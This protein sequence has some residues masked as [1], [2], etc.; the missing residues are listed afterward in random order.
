MRRSDNQHAQFI[1]ETT[2]LIV[3]LRARGLEQTKRAHNW[4]RHHIAKWKM[5][6]GALGLR[7]PIM[8]GG[9]F[10]RAHGV[11]LGAGGNILVVFSHWWDLEQ[12]QQMVER[13]GPMRQKQAGHE[14]PVFIHHIV[15]AGTVDELVMKRRE[16]KREVQDLLLEALKY[17]VAP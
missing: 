5:V 15:A 12:F 1:G 9:N 7:A 3:R 4:K 10:N 6:D 13:I 2:N 14:R 17:E 11:G 8:V 16:T